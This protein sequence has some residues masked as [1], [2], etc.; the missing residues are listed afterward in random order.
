[1]LKFI[2]FISLSMCFVIF[3]IGL[4]NGQSDEG[5]GV[6]VS[7]AGEQPKDVDTE[8]DAVIEG[9]ILR[10]SFFHPSRSFRVAF[11]E[12]REEFDNNGRR[13]WFSALKV[14]HAKRGSMLYAD[15]AQTLP[16]KDNEIVA[17]TIYWKD[18][19]STERRRDGLNITGHLI[20]QAVGYYSYTDNLFIDIY[21][22]LDWGTPARRADHNNLTPSD[23]QI[24]SIPRMVV[25]NRIKYRVIGNEEVEG[26]KCL[27]LEWPNRDKLWLDINYSYVPRRRVVYN[28][29]LVFCDVQMSDFKEFEEGLWLPERIER[30]DYFGQGA[31]IELRGEVKRKTHISLKSFSS[32][33]LPDSFFEVPIDPKESLVVNDAI[34]REV[35]LKHPEGR[36]PLSAALN[37]ANRKG[38]S[39]QSR[40][41]N[42]LLINGIGISAVVFAVLLRRLL[43]P[44]H[45]I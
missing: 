4:V 44:T 37:D 30:L 42:L 17:M 41:S 27:I 11:E 36:S 10:E 23:L 16:S 18:G 2:R 9:L 25:D 26:A 13:L 19:V 14:D 15:I 8:L 12:E 40:T 7:S 39:T 3:E 22:E 5:L 35:Y 21:K 20:G 43:R 33:L 24:L 1:M 29:G 45:S 31:P 6:G 38:V 32:A 34:R 28:E